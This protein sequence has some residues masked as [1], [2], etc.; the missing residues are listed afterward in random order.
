MEGDEEGSSAVELVV[1]PS[2][3]ETMGV[4]IVQGRGFDAG[5][6]ADALPVAVVSRE[7]ARRYWPEG[8]ALGSR[9]KMGR[10]DTA[11]TWITVV[12]ISGDVRTHSHSVRR[13]NLSMPHV[14]LPMAQSPRRESA[15]GIR[16]AVEPASLSSRVREAIWSVDPRQP[17]EDVN[18]MRAVIGRIDTQNLFFLRVLT[19]LAAIALLLAAVGIYGIIA[20]A[21]N[22]RAQEIGIRM[23]LGARPSNILALVVRQGAALTLVGLAV[24]IAG[25]VAFVRFMA[26]E[27]EGIAATNASGPLTFVAVSLVLLA[28]AQIASLLPARR[29]VSLD[30]LATLRRE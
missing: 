24:G 16:T 13:P 25:A 17:V 15:I 27:L 7:A 22:Q 3:F 14:F 19:T 11:A 10:E 29:A 9:L 20:F 18:P 23:A 30:P 6:D 28:V 2:Y 26:A 12:G 5:D 21:V 8:N 4:P 1:S